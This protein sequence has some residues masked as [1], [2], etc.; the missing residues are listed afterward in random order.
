MLRVQLLKLSLVVNRDGTQED[1][2]ALRVQRV[3]RLR[4][5]GKYCSERL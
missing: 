1:V 5:S 2:N 4:G 3:R